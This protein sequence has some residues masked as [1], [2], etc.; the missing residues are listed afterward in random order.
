M[1]DVTLLE[2][3]GVLRLTGP[4][5]VT[6]LQGLVSNDV[7]KVTPGRSLWA[8]FLTP[9]GKWLHDF[10]LLAA[11]EALLLETEIGRLPDLLRRLGLYRL[12]SK[13]ELA[14]ASADYAVAALWGPGALER[15]GLPAEPGATRPFAGGLA[16]VDPRRAA[17]GARALLPRTAAPAL[18]AEAGFL[19][20]PRAGY[21]RL[22]LEEGVPDGS[23]D[24]VP[25]K[26]ILLENGF[27]ELA[28]I[29]WDKG[30]WM[31][32]ELTARTKYRALIRKR[33]LPVVLDGAAPPAGTPV[34]QAGREVGELRSSAGGLALALLRLDALEDGAL[35][36]GE[37]HLA[38]RPP[39]W[40]RPAAAGEES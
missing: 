31:G 19:A 1:T 7:A 38:V 6:F 15:L 12:R 9:Q 32:Q 21:D 33:L 3:R 36:V 29:D 20:A 28:G 27:D 17:L 40:F 5:R 2:D 8:A 35:T 30:C 26:S 23:R 13:V 18:L 37:A 24:L 34:L 11:G 10:F 39:E 4:D 16:F 22:R 25:E 14:D